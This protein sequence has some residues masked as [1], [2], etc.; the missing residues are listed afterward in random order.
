MPRRRSLCSVR[1]FQVHESEAKEN[2]CALVNICLTSTGAT[3]AEREC[4]SFWK[5]QQSR[6]EFRTTSIATQSDPGSV[7]FFRGLCDRPSQSSPPLPTLTAN[8]TSPCLLTR[9]SPSERPQSV[10]QSLIMHLPRT[11]LAVALAA[12]TATALP[13][14]KTTGKPKEDMECSQGGCTHSPGGKGI[15]S[16][17]QEPPA[18]VKR[19]ERGGGGV[20]GQMQDIEGGNPL[21]GNKNILVHPGDDFYQGN[22]IQPGDDLYQGG[23]NQDGGARLT[24]R[25]HQAGKIHYENIEIQ[26]DNDFHQGNRIQSGDDFYQGGDDQ[27][28]GARLTRRFHQAGKI[29]YEK[30]IEQPQTTKLEYNPGRG[31]VAPRH[32]ETLPLGGDE[33]LNRNPI[34]GDYF[35]TKSQAKGGELLRNPI[36]AD[37]L[38]R[39]TD[40]KPEMWLRG[41]DL[42]QPGNELIRNPNQGDDFYQ[43]LPRVQ[44]GAEIQHLGQQIDLEYK[45]LPL[46]QKGEQNQRQ[47]RSLKGEPLD[48][49]NKGLPRGQTNMINKDLP[50][51][52]KD[53]Q[54]QRQPRNLKG[55]PDLDLEIKGLPRG[56]NMVNGEHLD[57]PQEMT[58]EAR[59]PLNEVAGTNGECLQL[60]GGYKSGLNNCM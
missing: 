22:P 12:T 47:P 38:I 17:L 2:F 55:E 42:V 57:L 18:H 58:R 39:T 5:S 10:S 46:G 30:N 4:D 50:R 54:N 8:Q 1:S 59:L 53:E 9:D 41:R 44:K 56:Q 16:P 24:R 28:G 36:P 3:K 33:F 13:G 25:F 15:V 23:D 52:Q 40:A 21:K 7:L 45:G 11:V 26:P 31:H 34:S 51:V 60:K 6:R 20:R 32:I 37:E 43:G 35:I 48:L 14:W 19:A 29:H 49:E 27:D